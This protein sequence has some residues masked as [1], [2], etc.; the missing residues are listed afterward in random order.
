[1]QPV[2]WAPAFAGVTLVGGVRECFAIAVKCEP[3]SQH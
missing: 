1:M 2:T 3:I